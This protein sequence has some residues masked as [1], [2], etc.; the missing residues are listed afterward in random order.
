MKSLL[1]SNTVIFDLESAGELSSAAQ[2]Y[3]K[4]NSVKQ[5]HY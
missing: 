3:L 2:M 5:A 1:Y 4:G